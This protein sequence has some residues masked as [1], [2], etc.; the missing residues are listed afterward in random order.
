MEP[1]TSEEVPVKIW[2]ISDFHSELSSLHKAL[3]I[4]RGFSKRV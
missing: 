4:I 1:I 3:K 2:C